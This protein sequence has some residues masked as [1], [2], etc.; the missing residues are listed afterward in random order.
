[1]PN[2]ASMEKNQA[3]NPS[4]GLDEEKRIF[5]ETDMTNQ[6]PTTPGKIEEVEKKEEKDESSFKVK[7]KKKKIEM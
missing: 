6:A 4:Q 7:E 1:M 3:T 5:S 2:Q